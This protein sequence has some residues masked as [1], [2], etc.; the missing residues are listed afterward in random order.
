MRESC[1]HEDVLH[2]AIRSRS[3]CV[4]K[5][6]LSEGV[7][8]DTQINGNTALHVAVTCNFHDAVNLLLNANANETVKD[9]KGR[10]PLHLAVM[11]DSVSI[12]QLFLDYRVDGV[13]TTY[14]RLTT[15]P[16]S[17][18]NQL[19]TSR[20]QVRVS[21]SLDLKDNEGGSP[22]H[23]AIFRK[24]RF[25]FAMLLDAGA[26]MK[27]AD[28]NTISLL[29]LATERGSTG[30]VQILLAL[31]ADPSKPGSKK[32]VGTPLHCA[33]LFQRNDIARLLLEQGSNVHATTVDHGQTPLHLLCEQD[34][35]G[36]A[37][38][39][40]DIL[41]EFGADSEARDH[42][43]QTPVDLAMKH[44][45]KHGNKRNLRQLL[46]CIKKRVKVELD[47]QAKG[48]SALH[49]AIKCGQATRVRLLLEAGADF[50]ATTNGCIGITVLSMAI[51]SPVEGIQALARQYSTEFATRNPPS[52]APLDLSSM[53]NFIPPFHIPTPLTATCAIH[54]DASCL[55]P[56]GTA[57]GADPL[58]P[59]SYRT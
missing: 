57:V 13:D 39:L 22:L 36:S 23:Y 9:D 10:T 46:D 52:D 16:S 55:E 54:D 1:K 48:L 43:N 32:R 38:E 17:S 59:F 41:L 28:L 42:Q 11:S 4:V 40:T 3:T 31:G 44:G 37:I 8:A 34:L 51:S 12:L 45:I 18:S 15:D 5:W 35:K 29:H 2:Q 58:D 30:I 20:N 6:L 7:D 14:Q 26:S 47:R 56:S 19:A 24:S 27:A 50:R 33:I 25:R 21:A 49:V 53:E